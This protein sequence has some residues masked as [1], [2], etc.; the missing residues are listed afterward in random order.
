MRWSLTG[1][2]VTYSSVLLLTVSPCRLD[3][4][5]KLHRFLSMISV[6]TVSAEACYK[7]ERCVPEGQPRVNILCSCIGGTVAAP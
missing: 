7:A 6:S 2:K 3:S 5:N 4:L 1:E